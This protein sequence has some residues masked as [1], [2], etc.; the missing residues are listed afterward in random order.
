MQ[1]MSAEQLDL[2][3][4]R[5]AK[6]E[7]EWEELRDKLKEQVEQFGSTPPRAEKSKRLAGSVYQFTLSQGSSTEIKDAEVLRIKEVCA[8]EIF[9][10]LFREETVYKLSKSALEFLAGTLPEAAPRNLRQLFAR[11]FSVKPKAPSLTIKK[12]VAD[13]EAAS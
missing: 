6:L 4:V 2:H 7:P 3:A 10:K 11:A 9:D 13:E 5:M 1:L 12:L 8:K